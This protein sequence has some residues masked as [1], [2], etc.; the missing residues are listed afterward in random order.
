MTLGGLL[1]SGLLAPVV[2]LSHPLSLFFFF[3]FQSG[4]PN[5]EGDR[6]CVLLEGWGS[7]RPSEGKW[8][9]PEDEDEQVCVCGG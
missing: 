6:L 8:E 4:L 1:P 2:R 3:S 7:Q 9:G 5:S